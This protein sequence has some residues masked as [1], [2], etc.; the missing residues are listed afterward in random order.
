VS[1]TGGWKYR[2]NRERLRKRED[3]CWLCG[4]WIDPDL[5]FP[6]PMSWTADHVVP[7]TDGGHNNG[8]LRAAHWCH[9][10]RRNR[11]TKPVVQHGREW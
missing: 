7:I 6:H 8:E 1:R 4:G 2:R 10:Q 11:R 5:T 9:N 3:T